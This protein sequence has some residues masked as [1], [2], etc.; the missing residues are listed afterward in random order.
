MV[1]AAYQ[2]VSD[3]QNRVNEAYSRANQLKNDIEFEEG[4]LE[5]ETLTDEQR[6]ATRQRLRRLRN[7]RERELE[8]IRELE[9]IVDDAEAAYAD[10]RSRYIPAYG[11][12]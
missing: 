11:N 9:W 1:W 7:D 4:Q 10:V 3:A 6:D 12:F 5:D 2:R 8:S